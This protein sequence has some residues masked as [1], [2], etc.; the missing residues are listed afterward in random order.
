M[1]PS[2]IQ[3]PIPNGYIVIVMNAAF[4]IYSRP[5]TLRIFKISKTAPFVPGRFLKNEWSVFQQT[6]RGLPSCMEQERSVVVKKLK[7]VAAINTSV[8]D[9]KQTAEARPEE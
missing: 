2:P 9:I 3:N 5:R 6:A 4:G 7:A 8:V 1:S